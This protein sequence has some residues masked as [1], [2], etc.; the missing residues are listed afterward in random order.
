MAKLSKTNPSLKIQVD[1]R[2]Q[3]D[4]PRLSHLWKEKMAVRKSA[5]LG[6][7]SGLRAPTNSYT[8][9]WDN[10]DLPKGTD[11]TVR[12]FPTMDAALEYGVEIAKTV[13]LR[14]ESEDNLAVRTGYN[15]KPEPSS[16]V[17]V[18]IET[19]FGLREITEQDVWPERYR[20]DTFQKTKKITPDLDKVRG[21]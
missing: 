2:I 20:T 7:S 18:V 5:V 4:T 3:K 12:H 6:Q 10:P 14:R 13:D 16:V 19:Q 15:P 17:P 21:I 9:K 1:K 11:V 8:V